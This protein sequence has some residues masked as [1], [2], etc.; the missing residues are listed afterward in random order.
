MIFAGPTAAGTLVWFESCCVL[1]IESVSAVAVFASPRLHLLIN[2]T[3]SGEPICGLRPRA[4]HKARRQRGEK[5]HVAMGVDAT[6]QLQWLSIYP[7]GT[8]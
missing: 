8:C 6:A 1:R 7:S 4:L 5:A 2:A 3:S